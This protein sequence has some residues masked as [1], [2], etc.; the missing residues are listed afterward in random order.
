[1]DC[2]IISYCTHSGLRRARS[3]RKRRSHGEIISYCT[4][5]GLRHGTLGDAKA[6]SYGLYL[7]ARIADCDP[8]R[9]DAGTVSAGTI[10]SY[11]THSGLRLKGDVRT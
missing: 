2:R 9:V 1:M 10:I 7:I 8:E 5:S 11:C 3:S 4:H 6:F